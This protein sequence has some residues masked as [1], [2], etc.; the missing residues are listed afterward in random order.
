VAL[1]L[2]DERDCR[3]GDT[4]PQI[5][6]RPLNARVS[7]LRIV[8]RHS[9]DQSPDFLPHA[10]SGAALPRAGPFPGHQLTVPS[11]NGVG[12]HEGRALAQQAASKPLAQ[13]RETTP[14]IVVQS[15]PTS[16]QLRFEHP[17]LFAKEGDDI[18][19]LAIEPSQKRSHRHLQRNHAYTLRQARVGRVF[20]QYGSQDVF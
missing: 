7:P 20:G 15:Q 16:A 11:K 9:H 17:V 5:L 19:L 14:L 10:R 18:A 3:T 6:Q 2:E 13:H 1:S 4:M 8:G 12:R